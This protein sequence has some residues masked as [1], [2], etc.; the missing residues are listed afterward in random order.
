[1]T[2]PTGRRNW[3][4]LHGAPSWLRHH[5]KGYRGR[6]N[7]SWWR[8]R[9]PFAPCRIF[10]SAVAPCASWHLNAG[11]IPLT[12]YA[13]EESFSLWTCMHVRGSLMAA[14]STLIA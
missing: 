13:V 1:M 12:H 5:L 9:V 3:E 7:M 14:S 4:A 2:Y 10:G 11:A 8:H 6:H